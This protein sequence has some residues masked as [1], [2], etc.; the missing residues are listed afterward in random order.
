MPGVPHYRGMGPQSGGGRGCCGKCSVERHTAGAEVKEPCEKV[1]LLIKSEWQ[2]NH[3]HEIG[4]PGQH[5]KG[6]NLKCLE[7]H[8]GEFFAILHS[9]EAHN[10]P[11]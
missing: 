2:L 1:I 6:S 4:L 8:V 11:T 10:K 3:L 9:E 7:N 5:V